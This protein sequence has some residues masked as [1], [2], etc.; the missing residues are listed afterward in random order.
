[1]KFT[2]ERF[3]PG[4]TDMALAMEHINRY[5]F[6]C[7]LIKG[8]DVLDIACGA[9]Y[10]SHR[11]AQVAHSVMGADISEEAI[12]Y[13]KE[14][15]VQDNL[16]YA[17]AKA[18]DMPFSDGQFDAV[19]SF[20]TLE[21]IDEI[22]Q[23]AFIREVRRVLRPG[24]L[25][26]ISTPNKEVYDKRGENEFHEHELSRS[27]FLYLMESNF[28]HVQC[29][30]QMAEVCDLLISE[31]NSKGIV[32]EGPSRDK[33]E[34]LIAICSDDVLPEIKSSVLPRADGRLR[35]LTEWAIE[36]HKTNEENVKEIDRL[37]RYVEELSQWGKEQGVELSG[38]NR[39]VEEYVKQNEIN[40]RE[41]N[42]RA[43]QIKNLSEQTHEQEKE[44]VRLNQR[45][46]DLSQWGK[47]QNQEI[48]KERFVNREKDAIIE[49]KEIS[50]AALQ[51]RIEAQSHQMKEVQSH[52]ETLIKERDAL[53]QEDYR[54]N[55]R[56]EELSSWGISLDQEIA[57]V[58]ELLRTE[59]ERASMIESTSCSMN[60]K[61]TQLQEKE[62][63]LYLIESSKAWKLARGLQKISG[64]IL[65]MG[66]RRRLIVRYLFKAVRHP[67]RMIKGMTG[68]K[69]RNFGG[70]LRH[71][72]R[73]YIDMP[74]DTQG[75]IEP[76]KE[77]RPVEAAVGKSADEYETLIFPAYKN[78]L[79]SIV[80]PVYNQFE[81]TYE[82]LRSIL[83]N[84]TDTEYEIL[85]ADDG[86]S[87]LTREV[88]KIVRNIRVVRS[89]VNLR[90]LRN[91]NHAAEH[92]MGEYI[93]F[94]NNDTQ[95]QVGWLSSLMD[96]MR[97]DISIGMA[98]S[99]L[100][101][102]DGRLQE[103]G[104]IIWQ[105]GRAWNYGRM[106][107]P[108]AS[109]FNYVKEVD[110]ISGAAILIRTSLWREIGGFDER[111]APA[112]N[113]DSD[114]AF[115]VRKHGYKVVYQPESVVVHFEG[116][117]N[118][119]DTTSG[120]KSYQVINTAKFC[121]KWRDVLAREQLPNGEDVFLARDRGMGKKT[122]LVIDHYV[123]HYDRDAGSKTVFQYLR[124]FTAAGMNVKF[125]G[126]NFF[127]H[128][129]YTTSLQ[130]MGIEVLY[131]PDYAA[132]WDTW[133]RENGRYFHYVLLNRPHVSEKY[134]DAVKKYTD[135]KVLYYG[136]DL[137]F[138]R[139]LRR[140][141]LTG[142]KEALT[143]SESWK[144]RELSLMRRSDVVYYPSDIE[145]NEIAK[146]DQTIRAEAIPAY[147]F[148]GSDPTPYRAA[149]RKDAMFIGGFRHTPNVDAVKWL[150]EEIWPLVKDKLPE[151][152]IFIVG[153]DPTDEIKALNDDRFIIT[154]SV[155]DEE[156]DRMYH[157][158]RLSVVPLRYGAG[159][160]G[161]VVEAMYHGVPVLTT[162]VGAEG[163][164]CSNGMLVI[165]DDAKRF[166]KHL[167]SI[168]R[169]TARL[170]RISSQ[171]RESIG[172]IYSFEHAK[173]VLSKQI[174]F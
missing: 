114:L 53:Q 7:N 57:R 71:G 141:E 119:T 154:G 153:S 29:H 95:V 142:E 58:G 54:L 52:Q 78:P 172:S 133:L 56:I 129:P 31:T 26:I 48:E 166:A 125:I 106:E 47:A 93:Y 98:G 34:Y 156:L 132:N 45:I 165:G 127:R 105:D 32:G 148:D 161:K 89:D 64:A 22:K 19:V 101:Y 173:D 124:L 104:G 144:K 37:S 25:L 61:I 137:H 2:G 168:Y 121:E 10:G 38:L 6:A 59:Q 50:I 94:L 63:R 77:V 149:D 97:K 139:E 90:F 112:Y 135:A 60:L 157:E 100:V 16:Q 49:A 3:I 122:I 164:E 155:S 138:L 12:K 66:S 81:Y 1:M 118:G 108:E 13:C 84:T 143:L 140:Y 5:R 39:R 62:L 51:T 145:V 23:K 87:D 123:P 99:K 11:M 65:P 79:V 18:E 68:G 120:Q 55:A 73:D 131:G 170:N 117:S 75:H 83:R 14:S 167:L 17:V 27:E 42:H 80:I 158:C 103:A 86:S 82:C 128:E 162:S 88:D 30:L 91:C 36:N 126:D 21:H 147:L 67:I 146:I 152:R 136:H 8:K 44:L 174:Q 115:E 107:D 20:E 110:Y 33:A 40:E 96:T 43:A 85:I 35:A 160:K 15:Y 113:E 74:T 69:L 150:H 102:A 41:I 159:I 72:D 163:I 134:I 4:Q 9:G 28:A 169:D 116:V 130:Q 46:E 151:L 92:A 109:Q 24:G 171:Y 76:P 70:R 111:F